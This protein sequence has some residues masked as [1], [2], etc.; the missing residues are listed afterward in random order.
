MKNTVKIALCAIMMAVCTTALQ[1]QENN[2]SNNQ[3]MT[4]EQLAEAQGKHIAYE[5]AFDEQATQKFL[6]TWLAFRRGLDSWCRSH[7]ERCQDEQRPC[8]ER[9]DSSGCVQTDHRRLRRHRLL[10]QLQGVD[11]HADSHR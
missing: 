2:Q 3:R 8:G 10:G 11:I 9:F 1:A 7:A 4:R 5:L 6:A